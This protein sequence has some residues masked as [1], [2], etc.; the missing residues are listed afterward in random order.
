MSWLEIKNRI[1]EL[2]AARDAEASMS[3]PWKAL[4]EVVLSTK[5][6]PPYHINGILSALKAVQGAR[7]SEEI[8]IL[9][10]GCGGGSTLIYLLALGYR[11]IYGVDMGN[12]D[13]KWNRLLQEELGISDPRFFQYD[14]HQ[15]PLK[16]ASVDFIF[17]QQVL[18]HVHPSVFDR[19]YSEEG[20]VLKVGGAAFHQVP[21]RLVPY[22]S[23]T[24]TWLIHYFPSGTRK[25][26]YSLVGRDSRYV[27]G[28]L[29]LRMPSCHRAQLMKY[30]GTAKDV[31]LDRLVSLKELEYY[32]GPKMLRRMM[33]AVVRLPLI[34]RVI[35][36]A[37][38][39]FVMLETVSVKTG[40]A[41]QS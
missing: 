31:T 40:L 33:G 23:H 11:G 7:P 15:L 21:H 13:P 4:V 24:R 19:Y 18:E 41:R 9:D 39:H 26:L 38:K 14:G 27:E 36:Q 34:G 17:S 5:E 25:W 3:K 8:V 6:K 30:I 37:L 16:D 35:G 28:M 29:Y 32:D 22:D 12:S 2:R 20:R 1:E 10:H